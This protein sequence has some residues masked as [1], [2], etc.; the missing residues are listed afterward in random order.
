MNRCIG[1]GACQVACKEKNRLPEKVYYRRAGTFSFNAD[2]G[3]VLYRY[4]GA[5][6]HCSEP[7]CISVCPTSALYK[8]SSGLVL[9]RDDLCIGCGRCVYACPYNAPV[10]SPLTGSSSKC[11]AC[12]GD[13]EC[14]KSCPVRALDYVPEPAFETAGVPGTSEAADV[15][16]FLPNIKETHPSVYVY[17]IPEKLAVKVCL[18]DVQTEAGEE[19]KAADQNNSNAKIVVIGG[20]FAAAEAAREVRA[21][22]KT[23]QITMISKD[24]SAPYSRPMLS[25]SLINGF[26]IK[27]YQTDPV[28]FESLGITV[29]KGVEALEVQPEAK[30]VLLSNGERV[31][32]DKL[33][34]AAGAEAVVLNIPGI[35]KNGVFTI[36]AA[37][38]VDALH[39]A[40]PAAK[41]AAV[42]GGGAI[43]LETAWQL[44]R[45]GLEVTVIEI[46]SGLFDNRAGHR[47]SE[48]LK[49]TIQAAGI[50]VLTSTKTL[51]FCG[52]GRLTSI[53][54]DKGEIAA[55]I[56]VVSAGVKPNTGLMEKAGI[57]VSRGV[58]VDDYMQTSY[59]DI[60]ACG[61]CAEQGGSI[62]ASCYRA[63]TQ[64]RKAAAGALGI[65][66]QA[67]PAAEPL[68]LHTAGT[69]LFAI[70][71]LPDLSDK[72]TEEIKVVL[73]RKDDGFK[74]NPRADSESDISLFFKDGK[75]AAAAL[76]GD[77]EP[78]A[79]LEK[80][81]SEQW[82]Q[83]TL[84]KVF[85]E[86][87]T[88]K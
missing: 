23:A 78:S 54:T 59:P 36:R 77:L 51:E 13:P 75:L 32:Y 67:A 1:C 37:E 29:K 85:S 76:L 38:D 10:L 57:A 17:N 19:R 28:E 12:G 73:E 61:D 46:A 26:D 24:P 84:I 71:R 49:E 62:N 6:N 33:I 27:R 34:Y 11:D 16:A 20:G 5:C 44:K 25:K 21:H 7:A 79:S 68:V 30:C 87:G 8:D 31:Y 52:N 14:V 58:V 48:L 72:D 82:T 81:V 56:A 83:Q 50:K 88:I 69:S 43:G 9:H 64:A 45:Y 15:P 86:R 3:S 39:A 42:I 4:S 65:T 22:S 47:L 18:A 40:L 35:E 41:A 80:A 55:D 70:G 53:K 60:Y 2:G 63:F 66:C 74:V